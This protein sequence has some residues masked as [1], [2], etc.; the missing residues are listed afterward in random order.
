MQAYVRR[1]PRRRGP[2]RRGERQPRPSSH[3]CARAFPS[4]RAR[5]P[6][7][8]GSAACELAYACSFL[9]LVLRLSGRRCD[10]RRLRALLALLGLVLHLCVLSES[11]VALAG[12]RA[13]VDE[14]VLS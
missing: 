10:V 13:V 6:A 2:C 9:S 7:W 5:A 14:Q 11:L 1:R 3:A 12:D 8:R 4:P